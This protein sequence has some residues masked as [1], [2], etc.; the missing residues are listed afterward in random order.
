MAWDGNGAFQ[1]ALT[2]LGWVTDRDA[3]TKI[4]ASR[5]DTNDNDLATGINACLTRDNQ[6]KPSADFR[7]VADATHSLGS[8]VLRWVWGYLSSGL[9]FVGASFT[10]TLGFVAP[11]ENRSIQLPNANGT[12]LT[13]VIATAENYPWELRTDGG[14]AEEP[15]TITYSKGT[16]RV[17]LQ[18][19]WSNGNPVSILYRYSANA[20]GDWTTI[21]TLQVTFD[22]AGN[23]TATD[24]V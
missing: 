7:P 21:G 14:T 5:H 18:P 24:W 11:T 12:L 16:E 22:G 20:G 23:V 10:T 9:K 17:Q 13:D 19:T 6:A 4:L 15:G 2:A 3:G 1:R 8:A